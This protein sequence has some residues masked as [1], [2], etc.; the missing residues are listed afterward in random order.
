MASNAQ[1]FNESTEQIGNASSQILQAIEEA[2]RGASS[3]SA[4]ASQASE[5]MA[6]LTAAVVQVTKGSSTQ[7]SAMI[8]VQDAASELR[9]TV[10]QVTD[11]TSRQTM[12][13][14]DVEQAISQLQVDLALTNENSNK[15]VATANESARTAREG[16]TA[17][18]NTIQGIEIVRDA[19]LTSARQ[20]EALGQQSQEID[21]IVGAISDSLS[22]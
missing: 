11:G 20:V 14:T 1:Y 16:S 5:Q 7:T 10:A 6:E 3:Q 17:V 4:S 18:T 2:A 12:S 15:V 21:Q 19:G 9:L 8:T 13:V 22:K